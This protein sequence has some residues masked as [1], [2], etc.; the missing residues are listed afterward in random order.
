MSFW[1]SP[2]HSSLQFS[3]CTK[4]KAFE[5][6]TCCTQDQ[7]DS[8][9][10]GMPEVQL[11]SFMF[12]TSHYFSLLGM[13]TLYKQSHLLPSRIEELSLWVCTRVSSMYPCVCW[14]WE[15]AMCCSLVESV[16]FVSVF[17]WCCTEQAELASM[18][19]LHLKGTCYSHGGRAVLPSKGQKVSHTGSH[20]D[21]LL[22]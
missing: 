17:Q 14:G 18:Q 4:S 10:N 12:S 13:A 9:C 2:P 7:R 6:V 1:I 22:A 19:M 3:M 21:R 8:R 15:V 16:S 11:P 5:E 20:A